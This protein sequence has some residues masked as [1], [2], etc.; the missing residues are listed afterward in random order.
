M[1]VFRST[2]TSKGQIT[3]PI[4]VRRNLGLRQG[5]QVEFETGKPDTII[6]TVREND[7]NP[8]DAFVGIAK[9]AFPGGMKEINAWI[10]DMRG[11]WPQDDE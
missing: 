7:A 10:R 8:F 3:I 2:V 11:D 1:P 6:R 9:G 5:D 4:E